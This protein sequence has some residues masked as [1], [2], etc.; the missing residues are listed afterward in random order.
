MILEGLTVQ[1]FIGEIGYGWF[2]SNTNVQEYYIS[3]FCVIYT[4]GYKSISGGD[5]ERNW[6]CILDENNKIID[7]Y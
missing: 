4:N 3:G 1:S 7:E 6:F 5:E 2:T